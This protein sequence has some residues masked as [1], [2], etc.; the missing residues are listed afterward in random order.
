L[1]ELDENCVRNPVADAYREDLRIGDEVVITDKLQL[2]AEGFVQRLSL[3]DH[4]RPCRLP[5]G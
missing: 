5:A 1:V 2:F 3:R 4:L